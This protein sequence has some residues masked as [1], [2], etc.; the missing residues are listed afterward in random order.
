MTKQDVL[1]MSDKDLL[2]M[3]YFL[4]EEDEDGFGEEVFYILTR[5]VQFACKRL[6]DGVV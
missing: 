2:E 4:T 6:I 1:H 5:N 3:D